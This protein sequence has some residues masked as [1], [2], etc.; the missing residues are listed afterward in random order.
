MSVD[1]S[2]AFDWEICLNRW[3]FQ[4]MIESMDNQNVP[5]IFKLVLEDWELK[6][7]V[8]RNILYRIQNFF[9]VIE[10]DY[11]A[12]QYDNPDLFLINELYLEWE[13]LYIRDLQYYNWEIFLLLGSKNRQEPPKFRRVIPRLI[14]MDI[15]EM[16]F[17]KITE[18]RQNTK[19]PIDI[20]RLLLSLL[21]SS[22]TCL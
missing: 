4:N 17:E 11:Q 18:P 6:K 22:G 5:E 19:L 14:C 13:R 2:P 20:A 1:T 15:L 12:I 10:E 8:L 21:Q 9:P 16:V 7:L 3:K